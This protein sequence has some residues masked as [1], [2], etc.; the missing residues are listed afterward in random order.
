MLSIAQHL[1]TYGCGVFGF[2]CARPIFEVSPTT[3]GHQPRTA[4]VHHNVT[5]PDT[6]VQ[7]PHHQATHHPPVQGSGSTAHP[8]SHIVEALSHFLEKYQ[9]LMMSR[10]WS[11]F[12]AVLP[13]GKQGRLA[14][15]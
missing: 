9:A 13:Q 10:K 2:S 5:S 1:R 6:M 12:R 11:F 15:D 8:P 3:S 4:E 7:P 14:L